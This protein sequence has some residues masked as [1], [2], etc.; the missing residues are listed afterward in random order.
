MHGQSRWIQ[1]RKKL[2]FVSETSFQLF[3]TPNITDELVVVSLSLAVLLRAEGPLARLQLCSL[4]VFKKVANQ[5]KLLYNLNSHFSIGIYTRPIILTN[6]ATFEDL[7]YWKILDQ[8]KQRQ[9]LK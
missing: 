5:A 7:N 8:I 3:S 9:E 6:F 2:L 1:C 4:L